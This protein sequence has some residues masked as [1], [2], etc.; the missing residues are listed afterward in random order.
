MKERLVLYLNFS[1]LCIVNEVAAA[2]PHGRK[3]SAHAMRIVLKG[4]ENSSQH[5]SG[6]PTR[7]RPILPGKGVDGVG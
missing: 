4:H 6:R 1:Y 7:K 2:T 5:A 3:A